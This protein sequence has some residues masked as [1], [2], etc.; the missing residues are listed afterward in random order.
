[1]RSI[2]KTREQIVGEL[3]QMRQWLAELEQTLVDEKKAKQAIQEAE[4][5]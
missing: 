2:E 4:P 1:M 3:A 5:F